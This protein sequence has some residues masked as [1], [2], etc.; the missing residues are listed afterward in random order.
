MTKEGYQVFCTYLALQRHFTSNYDYFLYNGKVKVSVESYKKR[1]D[2]FSFEKLSKIV[3]PEDTVDFLLSHFLENPKE[4]IRNMSKLKYDSYVS[5]MKRLQNIYS[6]DLNILLQ[7]EFNLKTSPNDIPRIH[8]LVL[9]NT[10]SIETLIVMDS[11][12]PFIDRHG[13]EVKVPFVFP[14]H[15]NKLKKY[16][17]FVLQ[18]IS[19]KRDLFRDV[20]KNI[21]LNNK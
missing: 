20:T 6:D 14:E 13:E 19:E 12:F 2:V 15:I 21:L 7:E 1:N 17:P 11:I 9:S 8:K 5:R 18:R 10:I 3:L 4:Y 16:R